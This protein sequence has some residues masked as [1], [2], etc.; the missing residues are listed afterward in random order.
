M[1]EK[2]SR[3]AIVGTGNVGAT[4]AY[5]L[6]MNAVANEVLLVDVNHEKAQGEAMDLEHALPFMH[7]TKIGVGELK[8]CADC[9][10]VVVTAGAARKPGESRLDLAKKNA[11]M[12]REMIPQI[13][14]ANSTA[15][16]VIAS[17][18]VDLLTYEMVRESGVSAR[19]VMGSGTILDTARFRALLSQYFEV[20]PRSLHAYIIGEHG[21]SEVAVWSSANIGGMR[22]SKLCEDRGMQYN[23]TALQG[24]FTQTRDAGAEVIKRKGATFYAIGA[25]LVSIVASILRDQNTVLTV[26][27]LL[28]DYYGISDVCLSMP[29]IVNRSGVQEILRLELEPEEET[30]LRKSADVLKASIAALE[31]GTGIAVS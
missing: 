24:I 14:K 8:D 7:P 9:D 18:P 30:M 19:Q 27:S 22:L 10:V 13:A 29:T 25:G 21:D 23:T 11:A 12:F 31:I 26:S 17:N 4:C 1:R 5:G 2:T 28:S 3:V 20:D 16:Y 15:I 6:L